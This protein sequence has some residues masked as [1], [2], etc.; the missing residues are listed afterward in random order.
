MSYFETNLKGIENRFS[1][2]FFTC[3]ASGL[4]KNKKIS[5]ANFG[6]STTVQNGGVS[7]GNPSYGNYD[8]LGKIT[9]LPLLIANMKEIS[10]PLLYL[11]SFVVYW[12]FLF[13][14]SPLPKKETRLHTR[15]STSPHSTTVFFAKIGPTGNFSFLTSRPIIALLP[16]MFR[17]QKSLSKPFEISWFLCQIHSFLLP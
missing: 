7:T 15:I 10:V 6:P 8:K 9:F 2:V 1:N 3:C 4:K 11:L 12:R 17:F 5:W 16:E 13:S 14:R